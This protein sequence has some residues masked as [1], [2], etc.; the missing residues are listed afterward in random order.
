MAVNTAPPRPPKP[1]E[2]MFGNSGQDDRRGGHPRGSTSRTTESHKS[3]D[4]VSTNK[5]LALSGRTSEGQGD[6]S[7]R[8]DPLDHSE[9]QHPTEQTVG[10]STSLSQPQPPQPSTILSSTIP[11]S[12]S[13]TAST[14]AA[15]G[16]PPSEADVMVDYRNGT[17]DASAPV[18]TANATVNPTT[19]GGS[20]TG[21]RRPET[22]AAID[23]THNA[24]TTDHSH[25]H[26][27]EV[28]GEEEEE[29]VEV[30]AR[31]DSG[32]TMESY[33]PRAFDFPRMVNDNMV[34]VLSPTIEEEPQEMTGSTINANARR[35]AN[36]A[37][38]AMDEEQ[39]A[40]PTY[41]QA[42]SEF[43]LEAQ[44]ADGATTTTSVLH[45][46]NASVVASRGDSEGLTTPNVPPPA[47]QSTVNL[48]T[49][50][51]LPGGSNAIG[52]SPAIPRS[53]KHAA[54]HLA[55]LSP[56]PHSDAARPSTSHHEDRPTSHL[57]AS[58]PTSSSRPKSAHAP[59]PE[60]YTSPATPSPSHSPSRTS[61]NHSKSFRMSISRRFTMSSN[62][63]P[64][65]HSPSSERGDPFQDPPTF[66]SD[67]S[68]F[69]AQQTDDELCSPIESTVAMTAFNGPQTSPMDQEGV[70]NNRAYWN[71][72]RSRSGIMSNMSSTPPTPR[73]ELGS[74]EIPRRIEDYA[75]PRVSTSSSHATHSLAPPYVDKGKGKKK[76]ASGN[77]G[78]RL[79]LFFRSPVPPPP[80]AKDNTSTPRDSVSLHTQQP[81]LRRGGLD[82]LDDGAS[83][84]GEFGQAPPL[85]HRSSSRSGGVQVMATSEEVI[86]NNQ[87]SDLWEGVEFGF[88]A[89]NWNAVPTPGPFSNPSE[90][91]E[92]VTLYPLGSDPF[93]VRAPTWRSLLRFLASQ[94]NTRIEPSVE[95]IALSRTPTMDLRLVVQFAR[96][97]FTPRGTTRD[98]CLYMLLHSEM[99][100]VS[101]KNGRTVSWADRGVLESWD[102]KALPYGFRCAEKSMLCREKRSTQAAPQLLDTAGESQSSASVRGTPCD[103]QDPDGENSMFVTLP[104]PFVRLPVTMSDLAMYLHESLVQSRK[105]GKGGDW[106]GPNL[107]ET[108]QATAGPAKIRKSPNQSVP[109]AGAVGS[110]GLVVSTTPR[111]TRVDDTTEH[112]QSEASHIPGM[113]RLAKAVKTFYPEEFAI[114]S[115]KSNRDAAHAAVEDPSQGKSKTITV[116]SLSGRNSFLSAFHLVRS[117]GTLAK[118]A[119]AGDGGGFSGNP[120]GIRRDT[121]AERYELVTPWRQS[122]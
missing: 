66:Q 109:P 76:I 102:T 101:S 107:A 93:F 31:S 88:R 42:Q 53:G 24:T 113:K 62:E 11:L 117:K 95:A 22:S 49:N 57:N 72:N 39:E 19:R 18:T 92:N 71:Q 112:A 119:I 21:H 43:L 50:G 3:L 1:P 52:A 36:A 94:S 97:P 64:A 77:N 60:I 85:D 4:D 78:S 89:P 74:D 26:R 81:A 35:D 37:V 54:M 15:P 44:Q 59:H 111:S 86:S 84:E 79:S 82:L 106:F 2:L 120:L 45:I 48:V 67:A 7:T 58:Q 61:P 27:I 96:N 28:G 108:P 6:S 90:W 51:M 8:P 121:N 118:N 16:T 41:D 87:P 29:G 65:S 70:N 14:S 13:P 98:I 38:F 12:S 47:F 122:S 69:A 63:S 56:T 33:D 110:L 104:P 40:P 100:A 55:P 103:E 25:N 99:P 75:I 80:P 91:P 17:V 34:H 20:E 10:I 9:R 116:S 115:S 114:G 23:T 30:D 73:S 83:G 46:T 105:N 68:P 5:V 32:M